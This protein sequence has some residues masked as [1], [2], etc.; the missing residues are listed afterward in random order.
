MIHFQRNVKAFFAIKTTIFREV[1]LSLVFRNAWETGMIETLEI[2][3]P[4]ALPQ[5]FGFL[6]SSSFSN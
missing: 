3:P 6:W 4:M 1:L 2:F 5:V